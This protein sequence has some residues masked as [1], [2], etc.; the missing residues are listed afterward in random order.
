VA[1]IAVMDLGIG[2]RQ[3]LARDHA[4]S[5]GDRWG[6]ATALEQAFIHNKSRFRDPGRGQ[7]LQRIRKAVGLWGGK[8]AIRSGTAR[9]GDVPDWDDGVPMETGLADFP[10]AQI[11]IVLPA[12]TAAPATAA[13]AAPGRA[14]RARPG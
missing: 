9:I 4:V 5:F 6:D 1:V 11:L 2:F 12:K 8:V 7:G 14:F 13:P 3:S 10:G